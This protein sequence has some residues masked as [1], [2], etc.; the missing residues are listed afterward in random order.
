MRDSWVEDMLALVDPDV[1]YNTLDDSEPD[2]YRGHAG[3]IR[4]LQDVHATHGH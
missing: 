3:M 1:V 4:L 2:L